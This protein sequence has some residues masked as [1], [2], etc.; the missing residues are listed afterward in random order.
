MEKS[1]LEK[2]ITAQV[3][4]GIPQTLRNP[5]VHNNPP[6]NLDQ[7]QLTSVRTIT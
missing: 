3:V 4:A 1:P 2:L 7:N 5:K 6:L